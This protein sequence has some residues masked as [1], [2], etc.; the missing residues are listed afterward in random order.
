MI[1]KC[2]HLPHLEHAARVAGV[3][4]DFIEELA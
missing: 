4:R 2:G 3:V 1:E